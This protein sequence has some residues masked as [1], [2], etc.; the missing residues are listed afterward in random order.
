MAVYGLEEAAV[1]RC[2][3]VFV[4]QEALL[5]RFFHDLEHAGIACRVHGQMDDAA[6]RPEDIVFLIV[7]SYGYVYAYLAFLDLLRNLDGFQIRKSIVLRCVLGPLR[8]QFLSK[9]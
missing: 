6:F 2:D 9:A 4:I 5:L 7:K 8:T 1:S 3:R